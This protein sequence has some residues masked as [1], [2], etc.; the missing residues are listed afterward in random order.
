ML[1]MRMFR[2][3][4]LILLV[5]PTTLLAQE[6]KGEQSLAELAKKEKERRAQDG[7]E[8][9][10]I[11]NSDLSKMGSARVVTSRA[12]RATAARGVG[13]ETKPA[14]EEDA[15]DETDTDQIKGLEYWQNAFLG[16]R[17]D[18]QIVVN[19]SLVT[20]LRLNNLRNSFLSESDGARQQQLDAEIAAAYQA[21]TQLREDEVEVRKE[22]E[23]LEVEAAKDGL[24]PGEIR[25]LV[26][27]LPESKTI[28]DLDPLE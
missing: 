16:A 27:K 26:G 4:I 18:L 12:G 5:L 10:L 23:R 24:L 25:K 11:T 19:N 20:Q 8:T 6:E 3:L 13:G 2:L 17:A 28:V 15:E 14:A 7:Q 9:R 21:L 1:S 22:I